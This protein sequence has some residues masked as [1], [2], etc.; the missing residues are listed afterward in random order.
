MT[1]IPAHKSVKQYFYLLILFFRYMFWAFVLELS[2]HYIYCSAVQYYPEVAE[3]FDGWTLCG[4]G[5]A[6]PCLFHLKYLVIYGFVQVL[7][8]ADGIDLPPPPKCITRIHSSTYL[9]RTFDRG[10]HLWLSRYHLLLLISHR[11]QIQ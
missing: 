7:G 9:W 2:L 1:V 5:Y 3:R 4:L 8:Q 6:L 10:L 11:Y